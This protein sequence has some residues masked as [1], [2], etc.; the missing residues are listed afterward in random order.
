ME[1]NETQLNAISLLIGDG[2]DSKIEKRITEK[3]INLKVDFNAL[4]AENLQSGSFFY[5]VMTYDSIGNSDLDQVLF[6]QIKESLLDCCSFDFNEF[7]NAISEIK[8]ISR[9]YYSVRREIRNLE[10]LLE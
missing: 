10:Q 6:S 4:F 1:L 8:H 3:V 2:G 5:D 7:E 9:E